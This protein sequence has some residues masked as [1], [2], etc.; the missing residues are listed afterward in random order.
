MRKAP[1]YSGVAAAYWAAAAEHRLIVQRCHQCGYL[2]MYPGYV[3]RR[4]RS[5]DLGWQSVS[6]KGTIYSYSVQYRKVEGRA[7]A[8]TIIAVVTL[9]EGPRSMTNILGVPPE[10]VHIGMDVFADYFHE[11]GFVLPVFREASAIH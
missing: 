3:C 9:E 5:Q 11:G 8:G 7:E 1:A 6:G 4:C 10:A 2:Q